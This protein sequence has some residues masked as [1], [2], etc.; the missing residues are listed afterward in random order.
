[1][2]AN[3]AELLPLDSST[4]LQCPHFSSPSTPPKE[5]FNR[6]YFSK[7]ISNF[8]T[9]YL[10]TAN[11]IANMPV[12]QGIGVFITVDG[13]HLEE[14]PDPDGEYS[15]AGKEP[16]RMIEAVIGSK[17]AIKLCPPIGDIYSWGTA[18]L[19][20]AKAIINGKTRSTKTALWKNG[21][22]VLIK[23]DTTFDTSNQTWTEFDYAFERLQAIK[24]YYVWY[25]CRYQL[26]DTQT[27][28]ARKSKSRH[29]W[30]MQRHLAPSS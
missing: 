30:V 13:V 16:T 1:L 2:F 3:L 21:K 14:Y 4:Y 15:E 29:L 5:H 10:I 9:S 8:P 20:S 28:K 23:T 24:W 26:A 11:F 27:W 17:F 22:S 7:S 18:N 19:L 6:H 25:F 12:V